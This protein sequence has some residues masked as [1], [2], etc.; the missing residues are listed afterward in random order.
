MQAT[1][2]ADSVQIL[3]AE[4]KPQPSYISLLTSCLM[5][6]QKCIKSMKDKENKPKGYHILIF[7][8]AKEVMFLPDFVCLFVCLSVC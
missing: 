1:G 2:N 8:F 4:H 7:A 5:F 3:K 6:H